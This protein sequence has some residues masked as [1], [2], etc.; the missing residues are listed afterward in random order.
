MVEDP[1]ASRT[2]ADSCQLGN[3]HLLHITGQGSLS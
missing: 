3:A 2:R 1:A